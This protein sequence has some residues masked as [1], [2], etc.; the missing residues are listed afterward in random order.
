M[1]VSPESEPLMP[2]ESASLKLEQTASNMKAANSSD[3]RLDAILFEVPSSAFLVQQALGTCWQDNSK[4][5]RAIRER[6]RRWVI[7]PLNMVKKW[8]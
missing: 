4:F 6:L 5:L 8:T 7:A 1:V 2:Q 3:V